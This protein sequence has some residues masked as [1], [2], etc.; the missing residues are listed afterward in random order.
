MDTELESFLMVRSFENVREFV[1]K[2]SKLFDL[3][4]SLTEINKEFK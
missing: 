2:A 4:D 3:L 1:K